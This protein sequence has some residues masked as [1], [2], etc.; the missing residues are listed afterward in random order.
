MPPEPAAYSRAGSLP[1]W[2]PL[3]CQAGVEC[4]FTHRVKLCQWQNKRLNEEE[5]WETDPVNADIP[6]GMSH[7]SLSRRCYIVPQEKTKGLMTLNCFGAV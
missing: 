6:T 5:G 3:Q 7:R 4:L 2:L 1:K